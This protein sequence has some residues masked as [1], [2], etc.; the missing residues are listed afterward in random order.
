[1]AV[2][3][4]LG[5]PDDV[6]VGEMGGAL[7]AIRGAQRR[8]PVNDGARGGDTCGSGSGVTDV[9]GGEKVEIRVAEINGESRLR[10]EHGREAVRAVMLQVV[11][12][13]DIVA[14]LTNVN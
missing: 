12:G 5:F 11:D 8:S 10:G 4:L 2:T 13:Q 1:M 6:A 9:D 14:I 3:R 7:V